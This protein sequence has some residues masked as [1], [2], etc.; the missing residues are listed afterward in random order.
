MR[1]KLSGPNKEIVY[2]KKSFEKKGILYVTENNFQSPPFSDES[3]IKAIKAIKKIQNSLS[4]STFFLELFAYENFSLWWLMYPQLFYKFQNTIDFVTNFSNF[5]DKFNPQKV[6]MND[7]FTEI[8]LIKQICHNK[9]IP[10]TYSKFP[11]FMFKIKKNL[12]KFSRNYGSSFLFNTKTKE[13]KKIFFSKKN[14]IPSLKNKIVF[15][16]GSGYHRKIFDPITRKTQSREHIIQNLMEL[17]KYKKSIMGIHVWSD[18]REKNISLRERLTSKFQWIPVEILLKI[19]NKN[20]KEFLIDYQKLISSKKFQEFIKFNDISLWESLESTFEKMKFAPYLPFWISLID[21]LT[22][23]FSIEK[24]KV[25]FIPYETGPVS[26]SF[27]IAAKRNNVKTI[28]IQ[29]GFIHKFHKNYSHETFASEK[30]PYGFPLPN[31]LLLYGKIT[32][33]LLEE[34]GYPSQILIPFGNPDFFNLDS[35]EKA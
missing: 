12:K 22:L 35:I 9:N 28:G 4:D 1:I 10:F 32:K 7:S 26:L 31:N 14:S 20:Q 13:R 24:P 30:N 33:K 25:I 2:G 27:I 18:I 5:I 16:A 23:L 6:R 11:F 29:H 17:I 8:N 15:V 21:S 34:K 19:K 3:S